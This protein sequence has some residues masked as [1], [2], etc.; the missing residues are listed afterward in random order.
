MQDQNGKNSSARSSMGPTTRCSGGLQSRL[1][2]PRRRAPSWRPI[3]ELL[4]SATFQTPEADSFRS[5]CYRLHHHEVTLEDM[6]ASLDVNFKEELRAIEQLQIRVFITILQQMARADPMTALLSPAV[7]G[8]MQSQME[9]KLASMNLKLPGLKSTMPGSPFTRTFNTSATNRQPLPFDSSSSFLS[10][11]T[12]NTVDNPSDARATL[13]QQRAKLKA[14]GNAAHHISAPALA[15]SGDWASMVNTPLLPIFLNTSSNNNNAGQ[16]VDITAAKLNDLY[17]SVPRLD[18]PDKFRRPTK[19]NAMAAAHQQ[20]ALASLGMGVGGFNLGLTSPRLAGMPNGLNMAQLVQL[21]GVNRMTPFN[22]NMNMP[23]LATMGVSPEAQLLAVQ[24]SAA[25]GGFSQPGLGVGAGL[26][27]FGGLQGG[28]GSNGLRVGSGRS[29]GRSPGLGGCSG[30][31][32]GKGGLAGNGGGGGAKK[33]E[34]DFGP[35]V[36]NDVAGWLR[37]LRLHKYTP[38]FEGMTWKEMVVMDEQALE[39][40]GI[41]ALGAHR[42]ILETFEVVRRKMGI[43]DPSALPPSPTPSSSGGPRSTNS[44]GGPSSA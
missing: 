7:G 27:S 1:A 9:A 41:A 30:S 40:Q 25:R 33:D 15:S 3:S 14:A 32:S 2:M 19:G 8:S 44:V 5:G 43:D 37:T 29:G 18:S 26:G 17:G 31:A 10:P 22:M 39:A 28:M 21:N 42:K 16:T 35:A 23:N 34:E 12:A 4:G 24:I 20:A 36:L 6:T 11:D 13:A 38:N